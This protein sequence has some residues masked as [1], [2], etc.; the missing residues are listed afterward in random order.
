MLLS[1]PSGSGYDLFNPPPPLI[2]NKLDQKLIR[3]V[4]KSFIRLTLI[5]SLCDMYLNGKNDQSGEDKGTQQSPSM[6]NAI[7]RL[8]SQFNKNQ[9]RSASLIFIRA[10]GGECHKTR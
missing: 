9:D 8:S 1:V 2:S 10:N 5:D 7:A 6:N 3:C 4:Q